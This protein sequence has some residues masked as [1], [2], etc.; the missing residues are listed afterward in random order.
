MFSKY[1]AKDEAYYHVTVLRQHFLLAIHSMPE[2][3]LSSSKNNA[4]ANQ[5]HDAVE[6]LLH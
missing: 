1:A 6:F 5:A 4:S 2:N 3:S